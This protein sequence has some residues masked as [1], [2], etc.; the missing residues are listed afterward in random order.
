MRWSV[1]YDGHRCVRATADCPKVVE[2]T[3]G[4]GTE[5][6]PTPAPDAYQRLLAHF[7]DYPSQPFRTRELHEL[8]GLPTDEAG[9]VAGGA[10]PGRGT[11]T[12]PTT[13]S[14]MIDHRPRPNWPA[15]APQA[16]QQ[17]TCGCAPS[18]NT[19]RPESRARTFDEPEPLT[20]R[21]TRITAP[22]MGHMVPSCRDRRSCTS[23][24]GVG[25][26]TGRSRPGS[27]TPPGEPVHSGHRQAAD[28]TIQRLLPRASPKLC[29]ANRR[30]SGAAT[31]TFAR[32][33]PF[34]FL[35]RFA[36]SAFLGRPSTELT[37]GSSGFPAGPKPRSIDRVIV[38]R[39][40]WSSHPVCAGRTAR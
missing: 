6:Q 3:T 10:R 30:P 11:T 29:K 18:G 20:S 17:F 7:D 8:L 32:S 9:Q 40:A 15:V 13:L 35:T 25:A 33:L 19:G 21:L 4:P 22:A 39:R 24:R 28:L 31:S 23:G 27:A 14:S 12:R 34:A 37:A 26:E 5:P 2:G 36:S 1:A 38:A 16:K